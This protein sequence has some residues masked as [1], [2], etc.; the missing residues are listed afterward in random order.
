MG[1]AITVDQVRILR[2]Q[3][4][5]VILIFDGDSA[6]MKAIIR[7]LPIFLDEMVSVQAFVLPSEHDPDSFIREN[8]V[9]AFKEFFVKLK[10]LTEIVLN[11]IIGRGDCTTPEGRSDLVATCGDILKKIKDPVIYAGYVDYVAKA[12]RI[13]NQL[14]VTQ[15]GLSF[16][17]QNKIPIMSTKSCLVQSTKSVILEIALAS[18]EAARILLEGGALQYQ[19]YNE[20]HEDDSKLAKIMYAIISLITRAIEPTPDAVILELNDQNIAPLVAKLSQRASQ[21]ELVKIKLIAFDL[22][23][24]IYKSQLYQ[25]QNAIKVAIASAEV[26]GDYERLSILQ[27]RRE[28]LKR[29]LS[30][31]YAVK[32]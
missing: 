14:I 26:H 8:G 22:T 29:R 9:E 1:T 31:F 3:A 16:I 28:E 20:N 21:L 18:P 10:P 15:L 5:N 17:N 12:L 2:G 30:S 32:E 23:K 4:A 19:K 7:S 24:E 6:G 11:H 27:A 25:K 13:D